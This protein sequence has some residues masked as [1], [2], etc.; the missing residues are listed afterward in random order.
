MRHDKIPTAI[1]PTPTRPEPLDFPKIEVKNVSHPVKK[2]SA[3]IGGHKTSLSLED[4]FWFQLR[5]F[6]ASLN[7]PVEQVAFWIDDKREGRN[8]SS[9]IRQTIARILQA[10]DR[11]AI[12]AGGP[13]A[14]FPASGGGMHA[15]E[16]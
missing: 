9:A 6:A 2:R 10:R 14:R 11:P 4:P 12:A 1:L 13:L 7:R 15:C 3:V 16:P 5:K 8:L